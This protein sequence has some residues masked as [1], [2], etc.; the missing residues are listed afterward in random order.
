MKRWKIAEYTWKP[1]TQPHESVSIITEEGSE[2]ILGDVPLKL[3]KHLVWVNNLAC[4][5]HQDLS[6]YSGRAGR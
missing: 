1:G 5:L 3:A 6:E 2:S 4:S